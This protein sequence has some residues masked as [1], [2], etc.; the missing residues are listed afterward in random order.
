MRH[1]TIPNTT[2]AE[3]MS[4]VLN[5]HGITFGRVEAAKIVGGKSRLTQ[6]IVEGKVRVSKNSASANS[7]WNCN[8]GDVLRYAVL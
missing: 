8:G 3:L 5:K 6:L 7:R 1:D 4:L 2:D